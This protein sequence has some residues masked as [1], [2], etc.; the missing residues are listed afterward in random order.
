[1][2]AE[3]LLVL[4]HARDGDA[5]LCVLG[6]RRL[7]V[8]GANGLA[9]ALAPFAGAEVGVGIR[10]EHLGDP[11]G[12]PPGCPRLHGRV[13]FVELL[14]AERHVLIE[15]DLEPVV[16]G[17]K[18]AVTGDGKPARA[19]ATARFDVHARVN[20]GDLTEVAV[21]PERL[22]FFDLATGRAIR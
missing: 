4:T 7:P 16:A 20:P 12:C 17:G 5:L 9:A 8:A 3:D 19:L 18:P 6:D 2:V 14:G 10:S 22:H 1:V 13:K 11:A 21:T 15:L